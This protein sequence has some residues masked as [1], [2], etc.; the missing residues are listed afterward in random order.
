RRCR[1]GSMRAIHALAALL[2]LASA[3]LADDSAADCLSREERRAAA[4]GSE[5]VRVGGVIR[6]LEGHAG[7]AV[8][9]ARLG[10]SPAGLVYVLTLL[11]RDGK[12]TRARVDASSGV[13]IGAR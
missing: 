7:S 13:L 8:I 3:A 12:V 1:R 10:R 11:G 5:I 4:A 9:G 2:L 6:S